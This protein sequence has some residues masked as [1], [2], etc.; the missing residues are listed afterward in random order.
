M[1]Q[2]RTS[3]ADVSQDLTF[4]TNDDCAV[5]SSVGHST[6]LCCNSDGCPADVASEDVVV[7][8]TV[9]CA[10]TTGV[11]CAEQLEPVSSAAGSLTGPLNPLATVGATE[12]ASGAGA[13]I[14]AAVTE[15]RAAGVGSPC[16]AELVMTVARLSPGVFRAAYHLRVHDC[17][18]SYRIELS[19]R[20]L[21]RSV[22]NSP[23]HIAV[24]RLVLSKQVR[25]PHLYI[26]KILNFPILATRHTLPSNSLH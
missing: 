11:L 1:P 15:S 17:T 22:R 6:F 7:E 12:G 8:G 25:T 21:G 2:S 20:V 5:D 9:E 13:D 19:A 16:P 26:F 23:L 24:R 4:V 14:D 3:F 10:S 18:L